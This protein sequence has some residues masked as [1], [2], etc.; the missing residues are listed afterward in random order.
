MNSLLD[1]RLVLP[2][3]SGLLGIIL[4][5]MADR[6]LNKRGRFSYFVQHSRVGVSAVDPVLGT[7]RVTWNNN[8]IGTALYSSVVE[9]R[10]ESLRDY[11]NIKVRVYTSDAVLLTE[12]TEILGTTRS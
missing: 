10:N 6:I 2:L 1:N 4:T 9:L 3:V 5:L 11:E 12:R 8:P 7:V